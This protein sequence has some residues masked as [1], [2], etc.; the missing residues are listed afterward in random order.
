MRIVLIGGAG[1]LGTAMTTGPRDGTWSPLVVVDS[2]RRVL[3]LPGVTPIH[4]DAHDTAALKDELR[5]HDTVV[6]LAA[7]Q[8]FHFAAGV[9]GDE[10]WRAN[11]DLTRSVTTAC[12]GR[13]VHRLIFTSSTSVYGS[14]T[15]SG[16]A[17]VLD[18]R[19]P[20]APEDIYDR[21]KLLAEAEITRA[22]ASL[23]GGA[24]CLRLG[25]FRFDSDETKQVR[26]LSTGLDPQ[27]AV[28][29]VRLV[30]GAAG[31]VNGMYTVASDHR[32]PR[33]ARLALGYDLD[34]I[35]RTF[36]P[37]LYRLN[38]L[39][40]VRLPARIQKTVSSL[41]FQRRFGWRPAHTAEAWAGRRLGQIAGNVSGE[42]A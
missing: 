23:A 1:R 38:R 10:L 22:A 19:T 25:R 18:E 15:T 16:P 24:V 11:V 12:V 42:S 29:A 9:A 8:G 41:R 31:S 37:S 33:A 17:A 36:M 27:D 5:P 32:L 34:R 26:K 6:H 4:L 28:T 21:A 35:V 2:D 39:G 30:I 13:G 20:V 3:S 7:L 40:H 14:G